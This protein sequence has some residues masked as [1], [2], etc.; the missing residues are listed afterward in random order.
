[1]KNKTFIVLMLLVAVAGGAYLMGREHGL[2]YTATPKPRHAAVEQAPVSE[3]PVMPAAHP[4]VAKTESVKTLI[5]D[6]P[7]F[8]HFRVGNRNVKSILADGKL[9]WVGTS[10]GLIRYD[11][12]ND[13][14]KLFDVTSGLLANGVF[15]V[16]KLDDHVVVGTYGGGMAVLDS[17]QEKWRIYNIP[18]GLADAFIYDVLKLAN[19]D[20]W[21]ATWSGANRVRGGALDDRTKW[22]LYTVENTK[23]GLPNDW[24]YG[25]AE[26]KDGEVW[27]ATEGGLARFKDEQWTHWAHNEGLGAPYEQVK[28]QIKFKRDPAQYS[29][30]HAKQKAEQGLG[31]V[32][33]AYNPNYIVS[34]L[35]DGDGAVWCGT[36]GGGLSRFDGQSWRTYTVSDGLPANHIFML[37]QDPDGNLWVGTSDGLAKRTADGFQ[38]FTTAN[39]LFSNNVFSMAVAADSTAWV[40]SY[41]GVARLTGLN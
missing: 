17:A 2:Q 19:G 5:E 10:G 21:I 33:I 28:D 1:M 16:G 25:L 29:Q 37:Y 20:V 12:E 15:Y 4:P 39:G 32:N 7:A 26:G 6:K 22:D 14:H 31:E 8:S 18:D 30:H 34:L 13:Q 23:G 11:T 3:Q 40:G 38:T 9:V 24:I 41:G 36:W 35:V 27:V